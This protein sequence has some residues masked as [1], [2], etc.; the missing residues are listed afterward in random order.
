MNKT[1]LIT[2]FESTEELLDHLQYIKKADLGFETEHNLI[3]ELN[4]F[5]DSKPKA[6]PSQTIKFIKEFIKKHL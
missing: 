3:T 6:T 4:W 1:T 5:F 2:E